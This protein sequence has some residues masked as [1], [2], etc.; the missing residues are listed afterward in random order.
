FRAEG[1]GHLDLSVELT[2][3]GPDPVR[4]WQLAGVSQGSLAFRN[5]VRASWGDSGVLTG[6]ERPDEAALQR[7]TARA[8][9]E[10]EAWRAQIVGE[11]DP[12]A[13]VR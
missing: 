5:A 3:L 7:M 12:R 9:E 4:D 10:L 8:L 1:G 2:P 6:V 13:P 11:G